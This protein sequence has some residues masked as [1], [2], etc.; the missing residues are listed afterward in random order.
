MP[1]LA[2]MRQVED[3]VLGEHRYRVTVTGRSSVAYGECDVC[4]GQVENVHVQTEARRDG[5]VW[6]YDGCV[7]MFGH[8]DCLVRVRRAA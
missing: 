8:R 1:D 3:V 4:R 6:T 5:V 7:S 2:S